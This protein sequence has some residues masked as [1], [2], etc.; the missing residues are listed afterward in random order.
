MT[1][2]I[3]RTLRLHVKSPGLGSLTLGHSQHEGTG[4]KRCAPDNHPWI[5]GVMWERSRA[6]GTLGEKGQQVQEPPAP[7]AGGG[8]LSSLKLEVGISYRL[9]R[10]TSSSRCPG[11][12]SSKWESPW[13]PLLVLPRIW[14]SR[15]RAQ[16]PERAGS[17]IPPSSLPAV[18]PPSCPRLP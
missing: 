7:E 12:G 17:Q 6:T 16:E 1:A 18:C 14:N 11:K 8:L 15:G 3:L 9:R 5:Y 4:G 13:G 2:H 10:G